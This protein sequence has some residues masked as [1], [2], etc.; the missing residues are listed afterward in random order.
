VTVGDQGL[1]LKMF[2]WKMN[3]TKLKRTFCRWK[4]KRLSNS[5]HSHAS[6]YLNS[7]LVHFV[8]SYVTWRRLLKQTVK[9]TVALE[10]VSKNSIWT[11]FVFLV[12]QKSF[13]PLQRENSLFKISHISLELLKH[14][15]GS[16][17]KI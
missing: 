11:F 9:Q 4:I 16:W 1:S 5:Q 2:Q 6:K 12:E 3:R 14:K 13:E 8:K 10:I 17:H 7:T 15:H